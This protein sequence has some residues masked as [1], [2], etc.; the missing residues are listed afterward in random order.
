MSLV[1]FRK[2]VSKNY[3]LVLSCYHEAGHAIYALLHGFA[4][5]SAEVWLDENQRVHGVVRY[6]LPLSYDTDNSLEKG[7]RLLFA[8]TEIGIKYAGLAAEKICYR[9]LCGSD[10]FLTLLEASSGEDNKEAD[11]II[12]N[13]K[14]NRRNYKKNIFRKI[15]KEL[16]HYWDAVVKLSHLLF[17]KQKLS[18]DDIKKCL[19]HKNLFW[20]NKFKNILCLYSKKINKKNI[21]L[22]L[23]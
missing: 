7:L 10:D 13:F 23:R 15:S 17:A 2:E 22:I 18:F 14:L 9:N 19:T 8:E 11:N 3:E 16:Q 12:K 21:E 4:V 20:K 5:D 1:H 6:N